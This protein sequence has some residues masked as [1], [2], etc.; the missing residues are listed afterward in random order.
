MKETNSELESTRAYA[1]IASELSAEKNTEITFYTREWN[2]E[3]H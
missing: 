1:E 2:A 3:I